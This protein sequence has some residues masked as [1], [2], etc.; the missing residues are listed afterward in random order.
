M[1]ERIQFM[2]V[3]VNCRFLFLYK[4]IAMK[5]SK[6]TIPVNTKIN[7]WEAA[8]SL[9]SGCLMALITLLPL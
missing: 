6:I 5:Q 9:T 1:I 3:K 4:K 2:T 7:I 8:S